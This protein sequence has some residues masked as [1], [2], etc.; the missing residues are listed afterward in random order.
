MHPPPPKKN[1]LTPKT[2]KRAQGPHPCLSP[3]IF[4]K[5]VVFCNTP[6]LHLFISCMHK[7]YPS[8][9]KSLNVIVSCGVTSLSHL[10]CRFSAPSWSELAVHLNIKQN[11]GWWTSH[12]SVHHYYNHDVTYNVPLLKPSTFASIVNKSEENLKIWKCDK[13]EV[14]D[15]CDMMKRYTSH[16][17]HGQNRV[18]EISRGQRL[19]YK[20]R[21]KSSCI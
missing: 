19:Q 1:L 18:L 16:V 15:V 21:A 10:I 20:C 7:L 5:V 11:L 14:V 12:S 9:S 3:K 6:P 17:S 4:A 8:L 2:W 13:E